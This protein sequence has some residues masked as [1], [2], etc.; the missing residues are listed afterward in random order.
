MQSTPKNFRKRN[1]ILEYMQQTTAH[2][3]ADDVYEALRKEH[4]DVSR[5]S[6]YRNLTLFKE[7]GKVVSLGTVD[8]I[9]RFDARVEPHVHFACNHC[10]CVQDV[11]DAQIPVAIM[12]E[13]EGN[14]LCR[15]HSAQL[16]LFGLC[17][18][19]VI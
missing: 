5:A 6:V 10:G 19:C 12:S 1:A 8:G 4:A 13:A 18:K 17:K 16:M 9:E 15:V 3:S 11:P 14:L 7:Q 2:P